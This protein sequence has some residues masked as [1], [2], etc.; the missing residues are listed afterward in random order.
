MAK[1]KITL[2]PGDG[3]GPEVTAAVVQIIECAAARSAVSIASCSSSSRR[4]WNSTRTSVIDWGSGLG[5]R[6]PNRATALPHPSC[7]VV[8]RAFALRVREDPFRLGI[9]DDSAYRVLILAFDVGHEHCRHVR[10]PG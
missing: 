7:D 1:H 8:L 2:L 10:D 4:S 3:I 5:G 9:L 6:S